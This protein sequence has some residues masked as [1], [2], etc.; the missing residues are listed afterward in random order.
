[1]E[2]NK[3]QFTQSI[4]WFLLVLKKLNLAEKADVE[5]FWVDGNLLFIDLVDRGIFR[6]LE[7]QL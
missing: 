7:P 4:T 3:K 1:M 5:D 2:T 6:E